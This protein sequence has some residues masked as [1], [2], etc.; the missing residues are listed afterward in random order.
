MI[1]VDSIRTYPASS[2]APRARRFGLEWCHLWSDG[3]LEELLDFGI[4]L[5]LRPQWLD[6]GAIVPHFDLTPARR[7]RALELGAVEGSLR[8]YLRTRHPTEQPGG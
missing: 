6:A 5:G 7:A 3:P 8:D 1:Y 4:R 2:V